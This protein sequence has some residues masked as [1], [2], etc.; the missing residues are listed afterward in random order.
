[1]EP[2][3]QDEQQKKTKRY[4]TI[5]F[6]L[7]LAGLAALGIGS[8][9]APQTLQLMPS[10]QIDMVALPDRVKNQAQEPVDTSLPVKKEPVPP[11]PEK[12][13]EPESRPEDLVLEQKKEQ[14]REKEAEKQAK[15]ALAKIREQLKKEQ[16]AEE[17]KKKAALDKR[18][19]D[20][21]RFEETYRNALK[22][23][24]ANQGSSSTGEIS[25]T[26]MDAY[27]GHVIGKIR[28]NWALPSFLQSQGLSARIIVR[29]DAQGRIIKMIFTKVS[30][31]TLF[32]S[33][34]EKAV[35][36]AGQFAPPPAEMASGLRNGGIEV[37][38]PL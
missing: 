17:A 9:F 15:A 32:D 2:T 30:G 16:Q 14:Q 29:I 28:S 37:K 6:A 8:F 4:V 7:H 36:D 35:R 18:R 24:Q 22:G 20:M 33:N 1:M 11:P 26:T 19:E 34:A 23:N 3:A 31:N 13:A 38:F 27:V 25:Q 10:V 12:K 21:K 5:S